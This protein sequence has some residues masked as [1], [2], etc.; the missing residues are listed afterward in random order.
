MLPG[1]GAV[2]GPGSEAAAA[3]LSDTLGANKVRGQTPSQGFL[4]QPV[5]TSHSLVQF[6]SKKT[7]MLS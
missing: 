3:A 6:L 4:D 7:G 5:T 1:H 2:S